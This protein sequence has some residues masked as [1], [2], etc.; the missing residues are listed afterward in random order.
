MRIYRWHGALLALER[1]LIS[2]SP[3]R[4]EMLGNLDRIEEP[5]NQINIPAPLRTSFMSCAQHITFV[6]ARLQKTSETA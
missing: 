4:K 6:R 3:G 5:V 2:Q 1:D